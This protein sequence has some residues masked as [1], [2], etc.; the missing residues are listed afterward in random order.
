MSR[1]KLLLIAIVAVA[2]VAAAVS[3]RMATRPMVVG[4]AV[5]GERPAALPKAADLVGRRMPDFDTIDVDG[6]RVTSDMLRGRPV[7]VAIW[8][9]WC[10]P[11]REEMPRIEEEIWRKHQDEIA[12][13]ALAGDEE[14]SKVSEFNEEAGYTFT[15]VPDPGRNV[16]ALFDADGPIPRMYVVDS[17]GL[18]VH[19]SV[20]YSEAGFAQTVA[21]VNELLAR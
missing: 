7:V 12:V 10:E 13:V 15:L 9:T 3:Y 2:A 11:C 6:R 20:G 16:T 19:Q 14:A 18:I 1:R 4:R 21:A 8:T 17:A 5:V